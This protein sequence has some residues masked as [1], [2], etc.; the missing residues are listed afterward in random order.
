MA[1]LATGQFATGE[2][3]ALRNYHAA[4]GARFFRFERGECAAI[5]L[6]DVRTIELV[7]SRAQSVVPH[8]AGVIEQ[9][10]AISLP[11]GMRPD[12]GENVEQPDDHG[13]TLGSVL[14]NL[15]ESGT[16]NSFE[17][18]RVGD[19]SQPAIIVASPAGWNLAAGHADEGRPEPLDAADGDSARTATSTS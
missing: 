4:S 18:S 14:A 11:N 16:C 5:S 12:P 7:R 10:G 15:I 2:M 13:D 3:S 17:V 8:G 1:D 9:D 6:F 19:D